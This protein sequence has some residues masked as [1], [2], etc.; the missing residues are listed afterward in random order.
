MLNIG[1]IGLG[2]MGGYHASVC[3]QLPLLNLVGIADPNEKNWNKITSKFVIKTKDYKEL[4]ESV[5]AVI[6][7]VPTSLHYEIA[8]ECL[9]QKKHV[10]LEKP[11]A[12]TID[13]ACELFDI[14]KRKKVALH[15]GHIER[16][17]GAV[18]ELKNI[19][20]KPHL[21]EFHRM[22]PFVARVKQDSIILDLMIH[23]LDLLMNIVDANIKN[24]SIH[25]NKIHTDSC[26]VATVTIA[27]ENGVIA[28]IISSRTSQIKKRTMQIHQSDAF[29][30][31]DF[32]TQDIS[33]HKRA[34]TS[35]IVGADRLKYRQGSTIERL[36]VYKENPLKLEIEHFVAAIK[37]KKNLF[38]PEHDLKALELTYKLEKQLGI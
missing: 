35:V 13:E 20:H 17:N 8:K 15:V 16:F 34:S 38:N 12:K 23:D 11:L 6:I 5:D 19:I 36:F 10:L 37:G 22:G 18:Q 25:G 3:K 33:I 30:S 29:I 14:A 2:H 9:L 32:T 26:D 1:I 31:L 4:L 27:F 28:N 21:I 7:A 24:V